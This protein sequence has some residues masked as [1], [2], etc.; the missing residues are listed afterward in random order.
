VETVE[1]GRQDVNRNQSPTCPRAGGRCSR[2]S[3]PGV[4][5]AAGRRNTSAR[6]EVRPPSARRRFLSETGA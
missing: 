3:P 1:T 4:D 6:G 2:R 5:S